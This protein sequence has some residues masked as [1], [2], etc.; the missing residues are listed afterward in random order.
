MQKYF[1][2]SKNLALLFHRRSLSYLSAS[3]ELD[4]LCTEKLLETLLHDIVFLW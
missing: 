4:E 3:F 2:L 1:Q